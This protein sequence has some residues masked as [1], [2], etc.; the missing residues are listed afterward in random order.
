MSWIW[1]FHGDGANLSTAAF[2]TREKAE[3][4]IVE[5]KVS[6]IITKMP[7]DNGI[8][9]WTINNDFFEPKNDFQKNSSFIQ[10]FTSAYLEHYHYVNGVIRG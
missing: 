6:G 10:K 9:Q 8:Y 4:W 5:N 3:S 7:L 1:I 2:S